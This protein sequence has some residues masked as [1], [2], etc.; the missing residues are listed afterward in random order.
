MNKDPKHIYIIESINPKDDS[1]TGSVIRTGLYFQIKEQMAPDK[2]TYFDVKSRHEFIL[3]LKIIK[4][5]CELNSMSP[6]IHF[7]MDGSEDRSG[8]SLKNLDEIPYVELCKHLAPINVAAKRN[9]I[10]TMHVCQ[11]CNIVSCLDPNLP[12]PFASVLCSK[13]DIGVWEPLDGFI[14]FYTR[15]IET[16]DM[17]QSISQFRND[18]PRYQHQFQFISRR[19]ISNML[20][21]KMYENFRTT[22]IKQYLIENKFNF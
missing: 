3:A 12:R 17:K 18:C 16:S 2:V 22:W 5:D 6:F 4:N 11:G 7:S 8:I 9:L 15:L 10:I 21:Q 20:S 14:G 19:M 13:E 1:W